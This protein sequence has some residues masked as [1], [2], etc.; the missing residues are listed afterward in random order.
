MPHPRK[1][2]ESLCSVRVQ[3]PPENMSHPSGEVDVPF[4]CPFL[5][6]FS[7]YS[8][9]R[10]WGSGWERVGEKKKNSSSSWEGGVDEGKVSSCGCCSKA[11]IGT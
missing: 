7:M 8:R 6:Y 1:N 5:M 4:P 2:R 3:P 10:R 9:A 11:T